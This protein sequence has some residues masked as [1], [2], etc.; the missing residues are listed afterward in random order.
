MRKRLVPVAY[1]LLAACGESGPDVSLQLSVMPH[2][3]GPGQTATIA[4]RVV[5]LS[6][7]PKSVQIECRPP[8]FVTNVL[9]DTVSV[10][11]G[12]LICYPDPPPPYP[13]EPNDTLVMSYFWDGDGIVDVGG[14]TF[15]HGRLPPGLYRVH[16][17]MDTFRWPSDTI[18]ILP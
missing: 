9:N 13:M 18:R 8:Y 12:I 14:G 4:L 2:A 6:G 10:P 3:I 5:N 11:G 16:G 15:V 1:L 17:N 7:R